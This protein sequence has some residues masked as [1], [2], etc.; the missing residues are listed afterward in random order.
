MPLRA[1]RFE[2]HVSRQ[3]HHPGPCLR[4]R[5]FRPHIVQPSNPRSSCRTCRRTSERGEKPFGSRTLSLEAWN[6]LR[7]VHPGDEA[8]RLR[9]GVAELPQRVR[10]ELVSHSERSGHVGEAA[11][12]RIEPLDEYLTCGDDRDV[13]TF[14]DIPIVFWSVITV[15]IDAHRS[16]AIDAAAKEIGKVFVWDGKRSE[17]EA[18][19]RRESD[20]E[21]PAVERPIA[22]LQCMDPATATIRCA[23][24]PACHVEASPKVLQH[25][26]VFGA[27]D[28]MSAIRRE[29][30]VGRDNADRPRE[31]ARP[32]TLRRGH[33][34]IRWD[35]TSGPRG[36]LVASQ[37][38][39][40]G[41]RRASEPFRDCCHRHPLVDIQSSKGFLGDLDIG[42]G[43]CPHP[44]RRRP[45]RSTSNR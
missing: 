13:Q 33:R 14:I 42:R 6:S 9:F 29:I 43:L 18:L 10:P 7:M 17:R 3:F 1:W 35:G 26:H 45:R 32:T 8:N 19:R 22:P 20:L 30:A 24:D 28:E 4:R 40:H 39:R 12:R 27:N 5:E 16:V 34:P 23:R 31:F 15:E 2:R 44:L 11:H 25:V 37:A 41:D 36:D 38:T 21:Q